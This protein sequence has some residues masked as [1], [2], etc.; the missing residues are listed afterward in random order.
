MSQLGP[1][2]VVG[3]LLDVLA[4]NVHV[5]IVQNVAKEI[6]CA[7]WKLEL[8]TDFVYE[9]NGVYWISFVINVFF[10]TCCCLSRCS[11]L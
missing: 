5:S 11:C 4:F 8:V 9:S 2:L 10:V 1:L 3:N 7:S 6:S